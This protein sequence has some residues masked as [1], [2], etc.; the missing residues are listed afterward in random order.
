MMLNKIFVIMLIILSTF[1]CLNLKKSPN[2][3]AQP[4]AVRGCPPWMIDNGTS[5][6]PKQAIIKVSD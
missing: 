5:C 1:S 2:T 3:I 6:V 4:Q